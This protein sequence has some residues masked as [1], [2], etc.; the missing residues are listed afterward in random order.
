MRKNRRIK[1]IQ[2][3]TKQVEE[4]E[5]EFTRGNSENLLRQIDKL[6]TSYWE[7]QKELDIKDKIMLK[8]LYK[9]DSKKTGFNV[10]YQTFTREEV[11]SDESL[12][13]YHNMKSQIEFV[14]NLT[15]ARFQYI[16]LKIV[17]LDNDMII[18]KMEGFCGEEQVLVDFTTGK[19]EFIGRECE[20]FKYATLRMID[21]GVFSIKD[22]IQ[23]Q[24]EFLKNNLQNMFP[25]GKRAFM[26]KCLF[27]IKECDNLLIDLSQKSIQRKIY[28]NNKNAWGIMYDIVN[29]VTDISYLKLA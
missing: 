29:G 21:D 16:K 4:I 15:Q 3:I 6:Q 2:M 10:D 26:K 7:L 12:R 11:M 19:I 23:Q 14:E 25:A 13:E 27:H 1:E 8:V 5:E 22:E 20:K 18:E 28:E 9:N 24:F 17:L